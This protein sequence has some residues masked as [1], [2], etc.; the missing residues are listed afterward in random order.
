MN[1]VGLKGILVKAFNIWEQNRYIREESKTYGEGITYLS[2]V[3]KG[4]AFFTCMGNLKLFHKH[5]KNAL[6]PF[7]MLLDGL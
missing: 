1:A 3:L 4:T 5:L 6:I 2:Q 7:K